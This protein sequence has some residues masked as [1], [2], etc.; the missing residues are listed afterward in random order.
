[1]YSILYFVCGFVNCVDV[2]GS[3]TSPS[4]L[5]FSSIFMF[6]HR[7]LYTF[8]GGHSRLRQS[9]LCYLCVLGLRLPSGSDLPH[10]SLLLGGHQSQLPRE[11]L[12]IGW[13]PPQKQRPHCLSWRS[14]QW[15]GIG[16]FKVTVSIQVT[17]SHDPVQ[18]FYCRGIWNLSE[19]NC[20]QC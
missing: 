18:D 11:H 12:C 1:M 16:R 6:S 7:S 19:V 14:G 3:S 8:S 2:V 4:S 5:L 17:R 10:S 20:P 15:S 13:E 9:L